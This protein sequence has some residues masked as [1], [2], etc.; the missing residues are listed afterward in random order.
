M[1]QTCWSNLYFHNFDVLFLFGIKRKRG[2]EDEN[3]GWGI[4]R[5]F[6]FYFCELV[7]MCVWGGS[8]WSK[9][10]AEFSLFYFRLFHYQFETSNVSLQFYCFCPVTTPACQTRD[11]LVSLTS[12]LHLDM[13]KFIF[14]HGTSNDRPPHEV[15]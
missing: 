13:T 14:I 12:R 11:A 1:T 9:L 7:N 4:E 3:V 8:F 6:Y 5:C 10:N 2:N 15:P